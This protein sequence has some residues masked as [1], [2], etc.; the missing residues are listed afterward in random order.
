MSLPGSC[1]SKAEVRV[2]GRAR[3]IAQRYKHLP[4][5][6]KVLCLIPGTHPQKKSCGQLVLPGPFNPTLLPCTRP[7]SPTVCSVHSFPSRKSFW[8]QR[9][10][11][12]LSRVQQPPRHC[13]PCPFRFGKWRLQHSHTASL[14]PSEPTLWGWVP[15]GCPPS[16]NAASPCGERLDVSSFCKQ[17]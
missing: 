3:S 15:T 17:R 2:V 5:K 10:P 13:R 16:P 8:V 12:T 14:G 4:G 11:S 6:C 9:K 1:W 7:T